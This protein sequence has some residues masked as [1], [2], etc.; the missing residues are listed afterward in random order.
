[1]APMQI[2]L[3]SVL[4]LLLLVATW[5]TAAVPPGYRSIGSRVVSAGRHVHWYWDVGHIQV[6]AQGNAFV[7][8][9]R[10]RNVELDEERSYVAIVRCD[11]VCQ[12]A[13]GVVIPRL[14][15]AGKS[16]CF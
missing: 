11:V 10:A 8:R 6:A 16:G 12:G 14:D 13:V 1:M 3:R 2:P 4:C 15:T 7:A 5:A 9:M